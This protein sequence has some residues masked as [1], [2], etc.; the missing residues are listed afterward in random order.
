MLQNDDGCYSSVAHGLKFKG[1]MLMYDPTEGH[2]P[3]G[4]NERGVGLPHHDGTE[5]GK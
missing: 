1:S 5:V 3:V 2:H 4:A